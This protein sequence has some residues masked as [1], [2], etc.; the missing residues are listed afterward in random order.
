MPPAVATAIADRAP[1]TTEPE[2]AIRIRLYVDADPAAL[3][4]PAVAALT[5]RGAA[6]TD[7]SLGEPSLEDVFIS[8]T[9]RELR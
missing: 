1:A 5:S 2:G 7:L 6:V 3:L 9:G 4:G 8:L